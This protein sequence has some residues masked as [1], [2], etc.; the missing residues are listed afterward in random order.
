LFSTLK[1][2][3]CKAVIQ[4]AHSFDCRAVAVGVSAPAD[5]QTLTTLG[6]DMGQGFLLGK[7]MTAQQIDSLVANSKG[8]RQQAVS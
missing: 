2:K 6:C 8:E 4:M 3:I 1:D 5:L 7:P